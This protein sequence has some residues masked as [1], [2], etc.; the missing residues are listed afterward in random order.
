[1]TD[2]DHDGME[3]GYGDGCF[4]GRLVGLLVGVAGEGSSRA[5]IGLSEG[6]L[7]GFG[8]GWGVEVVGGPKVGFIDILC[9]SPAGG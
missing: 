5:T 8:V 1:M 6:A 7:V 3:L 9:Q 2:G 4:E